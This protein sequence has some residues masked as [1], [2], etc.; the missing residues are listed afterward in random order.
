MTASLK[1]T[2]VAALCAAGIITASDVALASDG[3]KGAALLME[4]KHGPTARQEEWLRATTEER[5]L[6]AEKLGEN[7]AMRLARGKGWAP[8]LD[9]DQKTV[10]Q[11]PDLV[12]RGTDGTVHVIEA[13]AGS[14]P[15]NR[16]YGYEQGTLEW[17]VRSAERIAAMGSASEAERCA[18]AE[19]LK[20]A[21][22]GGLQVH[23]IRTRHILGEPK[24]VV[25]DQTVKCTR[26][27]SELARDVLARTVGAGGAATVAAARG[28]TETAEGAAVTIGG[29][30]KAGLVVSE[31][32]GA[33]AGV[34]AGMKGLR[35]FAKGAAGVGL[36]V[37][38]GLRIKEAVEVERA[39]EAG[40]ISVD[41]R[42]LVHAKN[43]AGMAGGWGGAAG[44]AEVGAEGGAALGSAICPGVG[45]II[46]G[47][48]GGIAGGVGGYL[49]GE[50]L[51]ERAVEVIW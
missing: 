9:A 23:V 24:K 50:D 33:A 26:Q 43:A 45:T 20:A 15:L 30:A 5:T 38:G 44:G 42:N 14:S 27:A 2:L 41:A 39:Y 35:V 40:Q 31:G 10:P 25:I 47:I 49:G 4:R 6:L 19:V 46:G 34:G 16:A 13:K 21:R 7:G 51:G 48:L 28:A 22:D 17:A 8:I 37:D 36:V 3:P 12:Y 1:D 32:T 11:G 18:A 29:A